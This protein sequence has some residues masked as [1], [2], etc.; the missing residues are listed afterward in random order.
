MEGVAELGDKVRRRKTRLELALARSRKEREGKNV[1][2][3]REGKNLFGLFPQKERKA[4]FCHY[5]NEK[6]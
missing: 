2:R 6:E 1:E 3:G 4:S 5:F